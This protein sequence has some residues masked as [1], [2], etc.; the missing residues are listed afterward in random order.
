MDPLE[1]CEACTFDPNPYETWRW[2][3]DEPPLT[4]A[5]V[6]EHLRCHIYVSTPYSDDSGD[7]Y[8]LWTRQDHVA[9]VAYLVDNGWDDAIELE[10]G[11]HREADLTDGHHRLAA[12]LF[13]GDCVFVSHFGF[14]PEQYDDET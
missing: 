12:A 14:V 2:E 11:P 13:T 8:R 3:G 7:D 1:V 5:E 6:E 4:F 9:R 10:W